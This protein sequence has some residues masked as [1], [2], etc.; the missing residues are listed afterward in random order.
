LIIYQESLHDAQSTKYKIF[1]CVP[2]GTVWIWFVILSDNCQLPLP[3]SSCI[4]QM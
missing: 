1:S 3:V 4:I 2:R